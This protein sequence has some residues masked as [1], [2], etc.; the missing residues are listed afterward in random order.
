MQRQIW[1]VLFAML[2]T[3]MCA[4]GQWTDTVWNLNP[5][6]GEYSYGGAGG[7]LTGAGIEVANVYDAIGGVQQAGTNEN[8]LGLA[9]GTSGTPENYGDLIFTSGNE[10]DVVTYGLN[11]YWNWLGGGT[12]DVYGC[13]E[14]GVSGNCIT[15]ETKSTLLISDSFTS[16]NIS[17]MNEGPQGFVFGG[18]TGSID[19]YAA[20]LLG[21]PQQFGAPNSSLGNNVSNLP[22]GGDILDTAFGTGTPYDVTTSAGAGNQ[23]NLYPVPEGWALTSSL[24]IF[25]LGLAVFRVARRLGLIKE[26]AL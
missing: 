3:S 12:L 22:G 17:P 19:F 13:L 26:V 14:V 11:N 8:I 16:V 25:A 15:G 7:A 23:M 10:T 24:G 5:T 20:Q 1:V 4:F 9:N 6:G 18:L 2:I 21:V